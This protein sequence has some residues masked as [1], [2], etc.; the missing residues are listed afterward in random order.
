M[1]VKIF[2]VQGNK[3]IGGLG[4]EINEWQKKS[5][6]Q[7]FCD[8]RMSLVHQRLA[9]SGSFFHHC[10]KPGDNKVNGNLR[11]PF[12]VGPSTPRSAPP[13][14]SPWEDG[15][16]TNATGDFVTFAWMSGSRRDRPHHH[17]VAT[18][19]RASTVHIRSVEDR[20]AHKALAP[21]AHIPR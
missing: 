11:R 10:E 4:S 3:P 6:S 7:S 13:L 16:V 5:R 20:L 12:R 19:P 18:R 2:Y 9:P 8:A 15:R 14:Q 21:G 1:P 17:P